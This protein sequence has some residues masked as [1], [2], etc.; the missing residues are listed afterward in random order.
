[1][2]SHLIYND[3]VA[4]CKK[5]GY[6]VV[7]IE[8][9]EEQTFLASQMK[10]H[11]PTP[12]SSYNNHGDND[13]FFLDFYN[14]EGNQ[15]IRMDNKSIVLFTIFA[16]G[17]PNGMHHYI[18]AMGYDNWLWHDVA[19]RDRFQTVCEIGIKEFYVW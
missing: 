3:S 4:F 1:M 8:S 2:K 7:T 9:K 5:C 13:G 6:R 16:D 11:I 18:A 17:Q 10:I 19:K 12:R 14:P 15:T